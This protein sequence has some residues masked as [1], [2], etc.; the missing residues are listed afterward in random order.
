MEEKDLVLHHALQT[1][2]KSSCVMVERIVLV[3]RIIILT[4][5]PLTIRIVSLLI[6]DAERLLRS[7]S[8]P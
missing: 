5:Y 1:T 3:Y 4:L 2:C 6:S 8:C 7:W